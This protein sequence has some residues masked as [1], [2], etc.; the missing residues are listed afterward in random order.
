[1]DEALM[2]NNIT[3]KQEKYLLEL[4]KE[5]NK[6]RID[7][8]NRK[9]ETVKFFESIFTGLIVATV[10]GFISAVHFQVI[11]DML[12]FGGLL[13]LPICSIV[14]LLYG[15]SNLKR[16]S[17]HLFE[18][19][20]SMIKILKFLSLPQEIPEGKRWI[21][22]D[23]FLLP[24]KYTDYEYGLDKDKIKQ[25]KLDFNGWVRS[26]TEEHEWLRI[27]SSLFWVEIV[28]SGLLILALIATFIPKKAY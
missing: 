26:R 2:E 11:D 9:W 20:A 3:K 7:Y 25:K 12:V 24:P 16:E 14:A 4:F 10:A 1:M 15:M 17:K 27:F 23:K 5:F 8:N 28:I 13:L 21:P 6:N 18:E 19:E 22:G